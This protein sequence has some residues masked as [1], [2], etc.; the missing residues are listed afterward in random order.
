ML[1]TYDAGR[2]VEIDPSTLAFVTPVGSRADWRPN[3][4][5]DAPFP[6]VLC[7]AHPAYDPNAGELFAGCYG[8][9]PAS[10]FG[11]GAVTRAVDAVGLDM[12]GEKVAAIFG[13]GAAARSLF[14][15]V[16]A[17]VEG[18]FDRVNDL[19]GR[20]PLV[21]EDFL[22]LVRWDGSASFRR[23]RLVHRDDPDHRIHVRQ[24]IHQV[25]VTKRHVIFLETAFRVGLD[26][27][28]NDVIPETDAGDRLL[29]QLTSGRQPDDTLFYIVRRGDL[30]DPALPRD[31]DGTPIVRATVARVPLEADHFLADFDDAGDRITLHVA[32]APA[33]DLSEWVR[34]YDETATRGHRIDPALRGMMA[35]GA[36]DL[37]RFGR[38]VVDANTGVVVDG[39]VLSKDPLTWAIAL[40]AGRDIGTDAAPPDAIEQLYWVCE[41]VFDELLTQFTYERYADYAHRLVSESRILDIAM[42]GG[43][44]AAIVR[45]DTTRLEI[46]DHF[47]LPAGMMVGSMQFV[48]RPGTT[49][50]TEGYL[51]C[52][53]CTPLRTEIWILDADD[54][55]AGPR[56]RLHHPSLVFGFSLHTAWLPTVLARTANYRVTAAADFPN[57]LRADWSGDVRALVEGTIIPTCY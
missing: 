40:Y 10:M 33:T 49:G 16:G 18:V 38:Y 21:P 41:G 17:R 31:G 22:D 43:R 45:V 8:R 39:K 27:G 30:D 57:A 47:T 13:A 23:Y 11:V 9:S 24:S 42:N 3:T 25:A 6:L 14:R 53:V 50:P 54:L 32:H 34:G 15:V 55:T 4:F 28:F 12:V 51:V 48:A 2:P 19:L 44:H 5:E 1:V 7:P 52:S 20:V 56:A 46:A 26:H 29:R 35:V 36:M 37:N